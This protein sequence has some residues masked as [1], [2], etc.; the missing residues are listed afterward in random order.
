MRFS[1]NHME[2]IHFPMIGHRH[3]S[4]GALSAHGES[5]LKDACAR[6]LISYLSSSKSA[7]YG[8]PTGR[9]IPFLKTL[10]ILN[11]FKNQLVYQLA[12]PT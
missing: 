5:K 2:N 12:Y 7:T 11:L 4:I 1:Q 3:H 6:P 10:S 9:P 8:R